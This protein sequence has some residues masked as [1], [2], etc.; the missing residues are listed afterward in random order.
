MHGDKAFGMQTGED[1][2]QLLSFEIGTADRGEDCVDRSALR[3]RRKR[4]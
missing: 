2:T 4:R 3:V 1:R